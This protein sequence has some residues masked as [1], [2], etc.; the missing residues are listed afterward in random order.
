MEGTEAAEISRA[1][2]RCVHDLGG[3]R[4]PLRLVRRAIDLLR[5]ELG[6]SWSLAHG[7]G[8]GPLAGFHVAHACPDADA[9][10]ANMHLPEQP[11][12]ERMAV[13][14]N[15]TSPALVLWL[16]R[17]SRLVLCFGL[18]A[19]GTPAA[20]A[21]LGEVGRYLLARLEDA[22]E[23]Q[24]T[25]LATAALER[26]ISDL[27]LLFK[28]LDVTLR[29]MELTHVLRAFM[30]CVTSGEAIG[31]NRAF[32]LLLDEDNQELRGAVAVGPESGEE[33]RRIWTSLERLSLEEVLRRAVEESHTEPAPGS[34][35][36][37]ILGFCVPLDA[38]ASL[39]ARVVLSPE[40]YNIHFYR[41][42]KPE[43]FA[44]AFGASEFVVIPILGRERA[45]GVIVADNLYSND[46]IESDRVY[47]LSGLA[48]HVGVVI[49]NA[50]MFED[51][52]RRYAELNEVQT[53][54]RALLSSVDYVD[55]LRRIA[56]ISA[57]VLHA[58]GSLLY[59]AQ[60]PKTPPRLEMQYHVD[61]ESLPEAVTERCAEIARE[62][63]GRGPGARQT[64]VDGLTGVEAAEVVSA[65]MS[66]DNEVVG[67][68]MLY[69]AVAATGRSA[70]DRHSRRF[71]S[72]IAD[73][74]AI[75]V[76]SGRRVQTIRDDQRRIEVLNDLLHRNEKLAALGQ[77]SSK[78]AHEIRNPLTALG[79][80]A[81]RML[82]T[83]TLG[84]EEREAVEVI[85][86]ETSRLE[87]ILNDQ[88]AFV[89]SARLQRASTSLND[90]VH[91]STMLLR[92]QLR[93]SRGELQLDL[94][95]ELPPVEVDP[96]RMKQVLVNLL[97]NAIAA[98][99]IGGRIR[100]ATCRA[101]ESVQLEVANTGE[102][103]PAA[104]R[105][106]LFVPFMTTRQEG[107]GLGL[108]VVHQ[109]VMEHGARIEVLSEAP[110]GTI[111]RLRFEISPSS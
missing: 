104:V 64:H 37:R 16:P 79:G 35:A 94:A 18:D 56:Q 65:P 51:V 58:T 83:A 102:A 4:E 97:M 48:N 30:A 1:M 36:A 74:A 73:Q 28:G 60:G 22:L 54:N 109:I 47:L 45:L 111:F 100:V 8:D 33:A 10:L 61:G 82:R 41:G 31:F 40:P 76:L 44:E 13:G 84:A 20:R 3:E 43:P 86:Q 101:D 6:A 107:T 52:S 98:V 2:T 99:P 103:I 55:V 15:D 25:R 26:R 57:S 21:L 70:F 5:R 34:L 72:I 49:E 105:E 69:R 68:L 78:I 85:A 75:A 89:R 9:V 38:E 67:V 24:R 50:L 27:S 92:Q 7:T 19:G 14:G 46:A 95:T 66:S 77:A 80:F 106:L 11:D 17:H 32:L 53:I 96:D 23:L 29:S 87:R 93:A 90:L 108:A 88:L 59:I 91:E 71:L 110:W 62:T 63:L 39:L 42:E 81:R 12:A